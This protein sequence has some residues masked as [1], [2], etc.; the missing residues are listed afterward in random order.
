MSK[1]R[2]SLAC[3]P[4]PLSKIGGNQT[5][6]GEGPRAGW[7]DEG[8]TRGSPHHPRPRGAHCGGARLGWAP[9]QPKSGPRSHTALGAAAFGGESGEA[10]LTGSL[11][12]PG[13][14]RVSRFCRPVV[15]HRGCSPH[16]SA[17]CSA[18][19]GSVWSWPAGAAAGGRRAA[20]TGAGTFAAHLLPAPLPHP[21]ARGGP[22]KAPAPRLSPL[23]MRSPRFLSLGPRLCF[24][25][26][27]R[28]GSLAG[29]SELDSPPETDPRRSD[30]RPRP[31]TAGSVWVS[32]K[33]AQTHR[34]VS[35]GSASDRCA[36]SRLE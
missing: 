30:P 17:S 14:F 18:P 29:T 10:C 21:H 19:A 12:G 33:Q 32:V 34:G 24:H 26:L 2:L 28:A 6:A 35:G 15:P 16:S 11:K 4:I 3:Q 31:R 9:C 27:L 23:A 25:N 7:R 1:R 36:P 22:S 8:G 13:W 20:G 5:A